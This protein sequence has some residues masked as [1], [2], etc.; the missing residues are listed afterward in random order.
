MDMENR[1]NIAQWPIYFAP[2]CKLLQLEPQTVS[3]LYDYLHKLFGTIHLYTR[4]CGLDDAKQNANA[5]LLFHYISH[6]SLA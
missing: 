1:D 3:H 4:C 5:I 2:G 6:T